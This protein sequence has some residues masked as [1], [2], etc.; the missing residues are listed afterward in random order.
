[1]T[2]F[3][4]AMVSEGILSEADLKGQTHLLPVVTRA[5]QRWMRHATTGLRFKVGLNFT[6]DWPAHFESLT[7]FSNGEKDQLRLEKPAGFFFTLSTDSADYALV[8]P[9]CRE[10]E[11]IHPGLG[12]AVIAA[13]E[14]LGDMTIGFFGP[15]N[16]YGACQ[17]F[18][19]WGEIDHTMH[20]EEIIEG[21]I[22]WE[23]TDY[24]TPL[25]L[26]AG[27]GEVCFE[28]EWKE[29]HGLTAIVRSEAVTWRIPR[30]VTTVW[31]D[32]LDISEL[33]LT[34]EEFH[35][36]CPLW[37]CDHHN[38]RMKPERLRELAK[39]VR[40]P[41]LRKCV[42]V[43]ADLEDAV[44]NRP[45]ESDRSEISCMWESPH[46]LVLGLDDRHC[47]VG[48]M[49]DDICNDASQSG[50]WTEVRNAWFF[51]LNDEKK[52]RHAIRNINKTFE[53]LHLLEKAL[54]LISTRFNRS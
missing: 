44:R 24:L 11:A 29:G 38:I 47:M 17:H 41:D 48:R 15:W 26:D 53:H 7:Q 50:E 28:I 13:L 39:R 45:I 5:C 43:A 42:L 9:R 19:W 8:G 33:I 3:A 4:L 37:A 51:G 31:I 18:H 30:D 22:N 36:G 27:H 1:M 34:K 10:L 25:E 16:A 20:L 52:I 12:G 40:R 32:C 21:E 49:Y 23:K 6:D 2:G 54:L 46:P 14:E 35:E